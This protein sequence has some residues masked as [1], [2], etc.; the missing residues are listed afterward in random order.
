MTQANPLPTGASILDQGRTPEEWAAV[1][2]ARG[3]T[4]SPRT[5]RQEARR[6]GACHVLGHGAM[7]I[8]PQ[9]IDQILEARTCRSNRTN[10]A[11]PTGSMAR[12]NTMAAPSPAPIGAALDQLQRQARA[13]GSNTKRK[14]KSVVTSL[15]KRKA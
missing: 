8:T 5:L 10:A 4:V 11:R 1:F 13:T 3:M 15:V 7:L 14:G 12:S 9:Q 2:Q 6:L